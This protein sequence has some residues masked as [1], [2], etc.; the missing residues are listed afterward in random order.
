M[1]GGDDIV[2]FQD[3]STFSGNIEG[4]AGNDSFILGNDVSLTGSLLGGVDDDTFSLGANITAAIID[5]EEGMDTLS[6]TGGT[7]ADMESLLLDTNGV[8]TARNLNIA[9]LETVDVAAALGVF[10]FNGSSEFAV[11]TINAQTQA[12]ENVAT[13]NG[14][15]F[16]GLDAI[17]TGAGND[18]VNFVAGASYSG[19]LNTGGGSDSIFLA[20]NVSVSQAIE[21]GTN[22]N[23]SDTVTT[24]GDIGEEII[25]SSAVGTLAI[26][27]TTFNGIEGANFA[28]SQVTYQGSNSVGQGDEITISGNNIL[29][30]NQFQLEGISRVVLA[31]GNDTVTFLDGS[32]FSGNIEGGAGNDSFI[33]GNNVSLTGSLLGGADDDTFSLGTG[34]TATMAILDAEGGVDTLTLTGGMADNMES[35]SV[36]TTGLLTARTANIRGLESVDLATSLGV[37]TLVG[38]AGL[39]TVTINAQAIDGVNAA[40][41]NGLAF[42]G[43]DAINTGAG[44]DQVTFVA[45]ASYSGDLN[46]GDDSDSIFLESNVSVSQAIE[47]G[48][49]E[50]GSDTVTTVG[51]IGE[52]IIS[53]AAAGTLAIRGTTFNGIEGANFAGSQVTYQGSDS[54][55]QGDEITISGSNILQVNQFEFEGIS[56]VNLAAGNDTVTFLE[57]STFSGN[58]EGGAGNDSFILGNNVSL[59]GSLLGGADDDAFS[60][61]ANITA[62]IIDAEEGMDTLSLTGGAAADMESLRLDTNGVL[63]ARGLN[64]AGLET[65]DLAAAL[66]VFTFTGS[67]AVETVTI[68]A[69]TQ[70]GENVASI[71]GL[72]FEGLDAINTGAGNDQ[73]TFVAGA[74]YSGDLNTG[75][76]SDSISLADNVSVS[77]AIEL[78]SNQNGSD[79]VTTVGDIGEEIISSSAAGT[80]AIR[81]TT[82]NGIEGANFAGSQVTYQGS[83]SVGQG[84]EITISGNDILGVNQ[85]QLEGI[86]RV[87]LAAGNDTVTFLDG[88]TFSGDIEGG[89]GNDNFI[90]GNNVSLTGSLLGGADDDAFSLGANITAAIIDAE[91]G[92]DTLSLTGGTAADMESLL[93]DTN[94]V[95]TARNLNIAGLET[96][97]VATALGV[98]SFNG[99]DGADIVRINAQT[100]AGENVAVIEEIEF[101]GIDSIDTGAGDDAISFTADS[102]FSG[103]ILAGDSTNDNDT[104]FLLDG[105]GTAVSPEALTVTNNNGNSILTARNIS[106]SGLE[107][108]DL[109][110]GGEF[111]FQDNLGV[112]DV[113]TVNQ[114]ATVGI[115]SVVINEIGFL[116][117]NQIDTG[118]GADDITLLSNATYEGVLSTGADNDQVTVGLNITLSQALNLGDG[119]E[120]QLIV[121]E[122]QDS[123]GNSPEEFSATSTDLTNS[124]FT[125]RNHIFE[126][127][128]ILDVNASNF[129]Y[130]GG[131][132]VDRLR[133]EGVN[134]DLSLLDESSNSN[135]S[136]ILLVR[137]INGIDTN[138]GNDVVTLFSDSVFTGSIHT[139]T[140]DDR[141]EL[142]V[143]VD[144]DGVID[145]GEE[146]LGG[147]E[148]DVVATLANNQVTE[149]IISSPEEGILALRGVSFRNFETASFD[150]SNVAYVDALGAD[151]TI[152][153]LDSGTLRFSGFEFEGIN[154]IDTAGGADTIIF[155]DNSEFTGAI[156]TGADNDRLELGINVNAANIDSGEGLDTVLFSSVANGQ[157][158]LIAN[159]NNGR[160][161]LD[162]FTVD[163]LEIVDGNNLITELRGFGNDQFQLTSAVNEVVING[164]TYQSIFSVSGNGGNDFLIA[165]SGGSDFTITGNNS[166]MANSIAFTDIDNLTGSDSSD[167]FI[168]QSAANLSGS[169]NA[170]AGADRFEFNNG[171]QVQNGVN[172]GSGADT[173]E[174]A[175]SGD[176]TL[177]FNGGDE[178][179]VGGIAFTAIEIVDAGEGNDTLQ[180]SMG[181]DEFDLVG[182]NQVNSNGIEFINIE[183]LD[184]V[185]GEDILN[186]TA[187]NDNF[188]LAAVGSG[189]FSIQGLTLNNIS[190]IDAGAGNNQITGS[191][192]VDTFSLLG[193]VG[194]VLVG[195]FEF[196][197]IDNVNAAAGNDILRGSGTTDV[198]Q[199]STGGAVTADN[200]SF[201]GFTSVIGA[202]G[203]DQ[204]LATN[205]NDQITGTATG[206]VFADVNFQQIEVFDAAGG[207]DTLFGSTGNDSFALVADGNGEI[208]F[209]GV[210][211]QNLETIDAEAGQDSLLGTNTDDLFAV[212]SNGQLVANG[213]TFVAI[214]TIN[215][216]AGNDQINGTNSTDSFSSSANNQIEFA[217][218][219]FTAVE[220]V[221]AAGGNDILTGGAGADSFLLTG[222]DN[223]LLYNGV[224]F[225]QLENIDGGN[226]QNTLVG[227]DADTR[228]EF[229][230]N[231][232]ISISGFAFTNL[233]NVQGGTGNDTFVFTN[234]TNLSGSVLG[235]EGDDQFIFQGT[236]D[237]VAVRGGAGNDQFQLTANSQNNLLM[238]GSAGF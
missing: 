179:N 115:N 157:S 111:V 212:N 106:V 145:L 237:A 59:T 116:G 181:N 143:D 222:Q 177:S 132:G 95:L 102:R 153:V 150:E 191:S 54:V 35:L 213:L 112:N 49:N 9:G 63:T 164:I 138:G 66:G 221:N 166:L 72:A 108:V 174:L 105:T 159:S 12:G 231:D 4:G 107:T 65:V 219:V 100:Q 170:G 38:S 117:I 119:D 31:A 16:E 125:I 234:G 55:D 36:D 19:G 51:D 225:N 61:G 211:Y 91:E 103:T 15:A 236:V 194:S 69:Q 180:G 88:S 140:G 85:F 182:E 155:Q 48:T 163:N 77:Q 10:S 192:S 162:G 98:F 142:D 25:S 135:S 23:G 3:G 202:G 195:G 165:Q 141:V 56:R 97:D 44:N 17:N 229:A 128:E 70:A 232:Q 21:L 6:L 123:T 92:M 190:I 199:V 185:A 7:A 1:A 214:E 230:G 203:E 206:F 39:D 50:N 37:F 20:D 204:V 101:V 96:V 224:T 167:S 169:I 104:L 120:D 90:L 28:G 13:I 110:S 60:L 126:N 53:S 148:N 172:A 75:G 84:D 78:G 149:E 87:D 76:G 144:F 14:L 32:T 43:L 176:Q 151:D 207:S 209:S 24:V 147:A 218:L 34:L 227:T 46:T 68:N 171:A 27:G 187:G 193:N 156:L 189:A 158:F 205:A 223:V 57:G 5:A 198:F 226:G 197:N 30:V 134:G 67:T 215:A 71:N 175:G 62:S 160:F 152:T 210:L 80:L 64:I 82:F 130:E 2:T 89:A 81:G 220:T 29:G 216:L 184:G 178:F 113:V 41:I 133:I 228:F 188:V 122:S 22:E 26:R 129:V 186:G 121:L 94:G 137:G 168:F 196:R 136:A 47:L 200:I 40:T 8:L 235:Q 127:I 11:V 161:S 118:A 208:E 52:E 73:V 79:T 93:L 109:T 238:D 33:L 233:G 146:A 45:G 18:Q 58:I 74:S 99:S 173:L 201:S 86:S 183:N 131:D 139:G 42:E 217:D 114:Q 83:D 124:V 154:R